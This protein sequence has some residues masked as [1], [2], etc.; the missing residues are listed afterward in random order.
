MT[1]AKAKPSP[2]DASQPGQGRARGCLARLV[3]VGLWTSIATAVLGVVAGGWLWSQYQEHVVDNPGAHIER[4]NIYGVI[5]QES[6]VYYRD[7]ETRIGVFFEDEHR[8]FVSFD[9]LPP[10]YVMGIVAAEDGAFWRHPG[11]NPKGIARAMVSNVKSGSVVAGGSTLTQQTAKN[12]FYRPD[13]SLK[14]KWTELV[15]ALRLEAHYDKSE[16]LEFYANQFHVSGNGRGLGIAARYFFDKDVQQLSPLESAFMAGLV[17]APSYYDPFLGDADRRTRSIERAHDRT[18]YVL[19]RILKTP[20]EDLAGPLPTRGDASSQA[21][22]EARQ[23]Q[24]RAMQG[25]AQRLLDEGFELQ[26]KRGTFRY[27]SS[28]VLD[29]IGRRLNEPPFDQVLAE[30]GIDDPDTA[31]LKVITTLDPDAQREAIYGLWHHLSD[32][33]PMMEGLTVADFIRQD[34]RGPRFDPDQRLVE[35]EFKLARVSEHRDAGGKAHL[36]VDLGGVTCAVDR[37]AIVR[38]A[39]ATHRGAKKDKNAKVPTADVDAFVRAIPDDAVVWV[40]LRDVPDQGEPTCDLEVRPELQGATIVLEDGQVRAMVGGNDNR[41]FNRATALRQMG[42]TWKP[43][44][45]HAA[46]ELGWKPIDVMDNSRNVFPFSTTYYYPRPDHTPAPRVSMAWAGVNSEN[47]ASIWLLY[48]LTDRLNGEQVRVLAET[49]GMARQEGESEKDYRVRIQKMG[50]LPTPG[51]IEEGLFLQARQE[52]LTGLALSGH[53]EDEMA[54]TSLLYGWGYRSEAARVE[55]EGGRSRAWKERA[56]DNSWVHLKARMEP[57]VQQ[58][59]TLV[60]GVKLGALPR[61]AEIPD[62]TVLLDGDEL[63]VACGSVPEGYA[64]PEPD[65]LIDLGVEPA[66]DIRFDPF[67]LRR[68]GRKVSKVTLASDMLI[69]DRL[70]LSTLTDLDAG[71]RRRRLVRQRAGRDAPSLYDPEVLYWH[72]DFRVL[73]SMKYVKALAQQYGVQTP[74]QEVLSMPLGASEITLEEAVSVYDGITTGRHW[75]FPGRAQSAGSMLGGADVGE[76]AAPTLLI[77]EIRDID[78]NVIYSARPTARELAPAEVGQMTTDIL[79]NVVEHGTGRRARSAL[80]HEGLAIPLGGKTGTTNDFRNAAFM[81]VAP[82]ATGRGTWSF[83]EGFAVGVYV[84][85]DDNRPMSMGNL[86]LAGS[87]G[88]LPAWIG[89]VRGL[90]EA[91]LL[92]DPGKP[93]PGS[94]GWRLAGVDGLSAF[95][96]DPNT[97]L[98]LHTGTEAGDGTPPGAATVLAIT[99]APVPEVELATRRPAR[100]PRLAPRTADALQLL[101]ERR[102]RRLERKRDRPSVWD[103]P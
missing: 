94:D 67:G 82:R 17:K 19:G 44:V 6:P 85:Y 22:Y 90:Y 36:G 56:L 50:V 2:E 40:S 70:H 77:A 29:E 95:A 43:L 73:L 32:V 51:R 78:D 31:G 101:E 30:A 35:H 53:P 46:L 33:G 88:A 93:F 61:P 41:N 14:S 20:V 100:P 60:N 59:E 79:R 7:G 68:P 96:V 64:A 57:C 75:D 91:G 38:S 49:L 34:S 54:L 39:L 76:P 84:G 92:G 87:S 15:N 81:G 52:A 4:Q 89:A 66:E 71:I 72:Q 83:D 47:L 102:R 11:I 21:A 62:L 45:Y 1:K 28:A 27:D 69:D 74:I 65:L 48:H 58:H 98:A 97:G 13:R 9:E 10:Q 16:I 63:K 26:F 99:Q 80:V 3:R 37:D 23:V 86:R 25:E 5:V 18:R 24:A 103:A 12:L 8:E 42:S 55:R